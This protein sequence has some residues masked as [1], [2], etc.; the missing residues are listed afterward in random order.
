MILGHF[1]LEPHYNETSYAIGC[2]TGG[3][4]RNNSGLLLIVSCSRHTGVHKPI[5]DLARL[6]FLRP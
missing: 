5:F 2:I 4:W 6:I 1:S 3:I